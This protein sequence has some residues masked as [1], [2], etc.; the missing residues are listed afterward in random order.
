MFLL[1]FA[2][3]YCKCGYTPLHVAC[4]CGYVEIADLLLESGADVSLRDKVIFKTRIIRVY[5]LVLIEL[6]RC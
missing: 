2:F 4:K 1:I 5:Y 3:L 6:L